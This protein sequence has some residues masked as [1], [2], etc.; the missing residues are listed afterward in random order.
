MQKIG[1][2]TRRNRRMS[3]GHSRDV[4]DWTEEKYHAAL[5]AQSGRC[6]LC[7]EILLNKKDPA[8]DHDHRTGKAR[9]LLHARCNVILEEVEKYSSMIGQYLKVYE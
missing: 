4:G 5:I 6:A 3:G 2:A 1:V 9:G 8:R 7:W